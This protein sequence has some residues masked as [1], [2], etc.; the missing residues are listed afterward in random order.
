MGVVRGTTAQHAPPGKV[1]IAQFFGLWNT[2]KHPGGAIG[3]GRQQASGCIEHGEATRGCF[4]RTSYRKEAEE[5]GEGQTEES[6]H[7]SYS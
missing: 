7:S 3:I 5:N 6:L 4:V 1:T 2:C